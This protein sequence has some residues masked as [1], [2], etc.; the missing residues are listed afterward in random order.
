MAHH[1]RATTLGNRDLPDLHV[2]DIHIAQIIRPRH[3]CCT[4]TRGHA[5]LGVAHGQEIQ[6]AQQVCEPELCV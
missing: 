1:V 3:T 4:L 6:A 2:G 5:T